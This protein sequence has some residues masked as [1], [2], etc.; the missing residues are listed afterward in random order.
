MGHECIKKIFL[1]SNKTVADDANLEMVDERSMA[2][3]MWTVLVDDD[4]LVDPVGVG[5]SV[6][7]VAAT[8]IILIYLAQK[9]KQVASS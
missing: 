2:L 9:V 4:G 6:D 5:V 1:Q 8:N 7:P 3:R